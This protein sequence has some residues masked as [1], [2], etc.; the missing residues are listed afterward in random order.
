[1]STSTYRY[2]EHA[3]KDFE[4]RGAPLEYWFF[5]FNSGPLAFLVDFIVRRRH[6]QAEVRLSLWV[7]GT[8]R[9]ERAYSSSWRTNRT[10]VAIAGCELGSGASRGAVA[11]I[12]WQLGFDAGP[13]RIDPAPLA[14]KLLRPLDMQLLSRPQARFQGSVQVGQE[15]FAISNASGL[16]CHYWGVRLPERWCWVSASNLG[17]A[18]GAVEAMLLRSRLWG[19]PRA[20]LDTGYLFLTQG[21][22]TRMLISPLTALMRLEGRWHDFQLH[23]RPLTGGER[24]RLDCSAT[25]EQYNDLGESIRQT[26]L[27]TCSLNGSTAVSGSAGLEVRGF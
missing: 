20:R 18:D 27:G 13:A 2:Q 14:L 23:A 16:L 7:Q 6:H 5:K 11:D 21:D 10:T 9:V 25:P 3:M 17:D 24:I 8:G 19:L 1:M 4:S 12:E 26:L 15:Q 22:R